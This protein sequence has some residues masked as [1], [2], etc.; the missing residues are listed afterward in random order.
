MSFELL[1]YTLKA[2][3]ATLK[4]EALK[5]GFC[6]LFRC[7]GPKT[8][9]EEVVLIK[10]EYYLG[11]S[12]VMRWRITIRNHPSL[13]RV[14]RGSDRDSFLNRMRIAET[15]SLENSHER[16]EKINAVQCASSCYIQSVDHALRR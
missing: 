15:F 10:S 8:R 1:F 5:V 2:G 3:S 4:V 7:E 16:N 12:M 13:K 14:S 11:E 9:T 6:R